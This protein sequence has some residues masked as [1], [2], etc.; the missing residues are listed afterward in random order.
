MINSQCSCQSTKYDAYH[1]HADPAHSIG[2]RPSVI[3]NKATM[4]NQPTE[5]LL[6]YPSAGNDLE[7][8]CALRSAVN[9]D[10]N[11]RKDCLRSIRRI[12]SSVSTIDPDLL[13]PGLVRR[14]HLQ[15]VFA[16]CSLLRVRRA[17]N[18]CKQQAQCVKEGKVL[19]P[20]DLLP[21]SYPTSSVRPAAQTVWLSMLP[22]VGR[23]R[24]PVSSRTDGET[25][26]SVPP[27]VMRDYVWVL[28]C[29]RC[30]AEEGAQPRP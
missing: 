19:A 12:W 23:L 10:I 24:L 4:S 20:L 6:H 7:P 14:C 16:P 26:F 22:A 1:C 3:S 28:G 2:D 30:R 8:P 11:A 5:R 15:Q 27:G 17:V 29:L 21:A 9:L 13:Q 25:A 18:H